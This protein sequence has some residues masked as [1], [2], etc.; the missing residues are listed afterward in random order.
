MNASL[1]RHHRPRH[2]RAS[3]LGSRCALAIALLAL[4][5]GLTGCASRRPPEPL[6]VV[7]PAPVPLPP[8]GPALDV[9]DGH[10]WSPDIAAVARELQQLALDNGQVE[11]MRTAGNQVR[12][13]I[14][15]ADA[16]DRRDALQP[17]FRHFVERAAEVLA[18]SPAVRVRVEAGIRV[19]SPANSPAAAKGRNQALGWARG[20]EAILASR[21]ISADRLTSEARAGGD[22]EAAGSFDAGPRRY[23]ELLAADPIAQ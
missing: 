16:V 4:G 19:N 20:T 13:R 22:A 12:V 1:H 9:K 11:V 14:D 21:G 2:L 7:A 23:I 3:R 5:V 17:R 18:R 15:A 10:V 8:P 6:A